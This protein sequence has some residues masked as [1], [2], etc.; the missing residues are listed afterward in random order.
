MDTAITISQDSEISDT[1]IEEL[2]SAVGWDNTTGPFSVVKERLF[3]YFTARKDGRLVGFL[4]VLSDGIAD[5]YIQDLAVRPDCQKQ[6]IA[7]ELMKRAIR[8]LQSKNIKCIQVTFLPSHEEFFKKFGF[9]IFRAGIID[10][11]TMKV[12][13]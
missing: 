1:E 7:T 8:F 10:R 13:I 3:T 9:Y 4:D 12:K 5:A 2:R 6:G 11:D